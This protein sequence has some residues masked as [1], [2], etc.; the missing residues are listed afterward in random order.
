MESNSKNKT[1]VKIHYFL[2]FPF[3]QNELFEKAKNEILDEVISLT[4]V[5]P[6]HWYVTS[7]FSGYLAEI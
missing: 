2:F 4:Q 7:E 6:K 3:A 1:N 5:T